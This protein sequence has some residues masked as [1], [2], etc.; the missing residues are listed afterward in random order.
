MVNFNHEI[1]V[2][3]IDNMIVN[4]TNE[5]IRIFTDKPYVLNEK[6]DWLTISDKIICHDEPNLLLLGYEDNHFRRCDECKQQVWHS[7]Y[8]SNVK[9]NDKIMV[10]YGYGNIVC[11]DCIK[12]KNL[13]FKIFCSN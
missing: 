9:N 7:E 8:K 10:I 6:N 11:S 5:S 2:K 13:K 4:R 3:I 12:S 1:V